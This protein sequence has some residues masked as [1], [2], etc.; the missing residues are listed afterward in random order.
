[1]VA[2]LS[3]EEL[4]TEAAANAVEGNIH[5]E[6]HEP[7][8]DNQSCIEEWRGR[9]REACEIMRQRDIDMRTM[10]I[11]EGGN[12]SLVA[13]A[14]GTVKFVHWVSETMLSGRIVELDEHNNA[15]NSAPFN[16]PKQSFAGCEVVHP[17]VGAAMRKKSTKRHMGAQPFRQSGYVYSRC[18]TQ[19]WGR[20]DCSRQAPA[21][22]AV[23][24]D[25]S[26]THVRLLKLG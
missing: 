5:L 9:A 19:R 25:W 15:I 24:L 23:P 6:H 17:S 10:A 21:L 11:G 8:M 7:D 13:L 3:A 26:R 2:D 18:G 1:M 20:R 12:M 22:C 16:V 4:V 14:N